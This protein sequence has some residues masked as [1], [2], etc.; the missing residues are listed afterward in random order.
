MGE[1]KKKF[2]SSSSREK[3]S[4]DEMDVKCNSR[5]QDHGLKNKKLQGGVGVL[6]MSLG[7]EDCKFSRF[8]LEDAI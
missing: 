3:W 7:K 6:L 1:I 2:C 4:D 5:L 8:L